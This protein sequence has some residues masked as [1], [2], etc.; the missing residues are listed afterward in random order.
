[1]NK[2]TVLSIV[3]AAVLFVGC[4]DD[5]KKAASEATAKVVESTKTAAD[6]AGDA[7]KVA[8]DKTAEAVKKA[9]DAITE[10]TDKAVEATRKAAEATEEAASKAADTVQKSVAEAAAATKAA[11][12]DT[13][14]DDAGAAIFKKCAG[15][16]GADGKTKALGKSAEI[17]GEPKDD[18]VTKISEYKTGTRNVAGMGSLMKGQ[19][20]S[21]SDADIQAV[22]AYISKLK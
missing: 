12:T 1:M 15:C 14:G 21:L 2:I 19:V 13:S 8:V 16:H 9:G 10:A 6:S 22:A 4:G 7:A 20:A 17:A 3:A 18:L 11:V 5:T